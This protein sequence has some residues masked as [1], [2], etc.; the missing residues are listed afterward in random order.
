MPKKVA[1]IEPKL[2]QYT[3]NYVPQGLLSI[4]AI[5]EEAGHNVAVYDSLPIPDCDFLG[6]SAGTL[7]YNSAISLAKNVNAAIVVLGGAHVTTCTGD[8]MRSPVFNLGIIGDGELPMLY[9]LKGRQY[10]K[11]PGLVWKSSDVV[12]ANSNQDLNYGFRGTRVPLPA[13]HLW[14]GRLGKHINVCRNREWSWNGEWVKRNRPKWWRDFQHE[15]ELLISF[16]VE[17]VTITDENFGCWHKG[18]QLTIDALNGLKAWYC[19]SDVKNILRTELWD[20]LAGTKCKGI[21]VSIV[22][23]SPRLLKLIGRPTLEDIDMCIG[24]LTDA[25]IA[26]TAHITFGVPGETKESMAETMQWLTKGIRA[27]IET[28]C[29]LP[30]SVYYEKP[31]L[32]RMF[33]FEVVAV[34]TSDYEAVSWRANT[35]CHEDFMSYVSRASECAG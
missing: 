18:L 27:R 26:V 14:K 28:L 2:G 1:L 16:G 33:G 7:Q 6:I 30:G 13:Y 8:A 24:K 21:E 22:S 15:I 5:L 10:A 23:A 29:P 4:A 34:N 17:I 32:F 31:D 9:L 11:I 35:I 19:R 20:K 12:M 3:Y 25:G